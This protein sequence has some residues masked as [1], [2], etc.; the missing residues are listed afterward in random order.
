MV[1][2]GGWF[3][4]SATPFWGGTQTSPITPAAGFT[5][6]LAKPKAGEARE[7]PPPPHPPPLRILPLA[8]PLGAR[9]GVCSGHMQLADEVDWGVLS[10]MC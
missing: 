9:N 4:C 5:H 2:F 3:S 1:W 8:T 7:A 10:G 6:G